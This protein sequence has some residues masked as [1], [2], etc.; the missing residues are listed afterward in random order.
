MLGHFAGVNWPLQLNLDQV[1]NQRRGCVKAQ[2]GSAYANV[3]AESD[4]MA[5]SSR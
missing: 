2:T 1:H 4:S 5:Q 3:L